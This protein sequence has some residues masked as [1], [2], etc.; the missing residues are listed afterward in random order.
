MLLL[1]LLALTAVFIPAA[2]AQPPDPDPGPARPRMLRS[3]DKGLV[4]ELD[5][6][7]ARV[8]PAGLVTIPGL[9][10]RL[11]APGAP[12]LPVYRTFIALPP[13]ATAVIDVTALAATSRAVPA[14]PPAPARSLRSAL[15]P[16]L[17]QPTADASGGLP[18]DLDLTSLREEEATAPDPALY[19]ADAA[20]PPALYTLSAP[21][22]AGD[23]RLVQLDLTPAQF[24]PA[25]GTLTQ[26][27]RLRVSLRFEGGAP[28]ETAVSP[29]LP[30]PWD[31]LLLNPPPPSWRARPALAAETAAAVTLPQGVPAFKIEVN[32]DGIYEISGADLAAAG[33]T[34]TG[35]NPSTL[36]MMHRGQPVAYQFVNT[37]SA[38]VLDPA[39]KIRFYGWAFDGSRYEDMFVD[40]NYY[41]LW[42]GGTALALGSVANEALNGH[43]TQTSF[44]ASITTWPK[45]AYF[46]GWG[47]PW[48]NNEATAWHWQYMGGIN[49]DAASPKLFHFTVELP[50][51]DPAG[52]API[53]TSEITTRK[54]TTA[55][56]PTY[57]MGAT[58]LLND[59]PASGSISWTNWAN[60][61]LV[62]TAAAVDL[63]QPGAAGYPGNKVTLAMTGSVA[64]RPDLATEAFLTRITVEYQRRL[65]ALNDELQFGP[66]AAGKHAFPISGFSQGSAAAALVWDITDR[67]QPKAITLATADFSSSSGVYT[68]Q[69]RRTLPANGRLF[70][71]TTANLRRPLAITRVVPA[72][73]AP[74][75]G[76]Q[77]LAIT[78]DSLRPAADALAAHRAATSGLSPFVVDVQQV[79][80]QVGF[81]Y[82]LPTAIQ[83]YL[84][85][86]YAT[87]ATP[88]RYVVLFGDATVNPTHRVCLPPTCGPSFLPDKPSLLA[89]DLLFIDRF[90]G[91]IPVDHTY[92]TLAGD[93]L[94]PDV[95]LSRVPA[96]N[97]AQANAGVEKIIRYETNL[98]AAGGPIFF[99]ADNADGGG[100]F[101]AE[102]ADVAAGLPAR[103][104]TAA[105]CL[106]DSSAA[107]TAVL[108]AALFDKIENGS[109]QIM[110][111]R[112]HG[113]TDSWASPAI[114]SIHD[115]AAWKNPEPLIHIS[116]DCL[117]GNFAGPAANGLGETFFRLPRAGTAAHWSSTGLGFSFEH[118]VLHNAYYKALFQEHLRRTG[119]AAL[120]AKLVYL[121]GSYH[122]VEALSFTLLGDAA[123]SAVP[124]DE[125]TLNLRAGWNMVSSPV[126]PDNAAMPALFA[127]IL[128]DLL[129]VKDGDGRVF[130]PA[131]GADTIGS[132]D[133]LRG[134]QI[135][136]NRAAALTF[137][138][139]LTDPRHTPIPLRAGW[140]LVAYPPTAPQAPAAALA[141]IGADLYL[142]KNGDGQVYWPE[143]PLDQI[144]T[145]RPGQGYQ[146]YMNA[147]GT[148]TYPD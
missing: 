55:G 33:L 3:D 121:S 105:L 51:P 100:N 35:V 5:L 41:W 81:G 34:L 64:G 129:L 128:S 118:S 148:L 103:L 32:Q 92:S 27:T 114:M 106:P 42:P 133:A 45:T 68:W 11:T 52:T 73:L 86:A 130:W 108:R 18:L 75:G 76:A 30:G 140:N 58:A 6:P 48:V 147:P 49:H 90:Q 62:S 119:D 116:A 110:N 50:D 22:Q 4:F 9:D 91:L 2:R 1:L 40:R 122:P 39:D 79:I 78:H 96:E 107:S 85:T 26:A 7:P 101:C 125:F 10:L 65:L 109:I 89:T 25:R 134:Y 127:P 87:W 124:T 77:W 141:T 104:A 115:T 139:Q 17:Q 99:V 44:P 74:P 145:M 131:I 60:L 102:S 59:Q 46:P 31:G 117:D 80:D 29:A 20:Y 53:L 142:A 94:L 28:R 38:A 15:P 71:T 113:S 132:W 24:N 84:K 16:D 143:L 126:A 138:G 56:R 12:A 112:G 120:F 67:L 43:Q 83:S 8:S 72:A 37:G 123:M 97:L 63:R 93:D 21:Q 137:R 57:T 14:I 36:Q 66:P 135:Y 47:I 82:H 23:L 69:V 144:Q 98:P 95:A 146:V 136:M 111:Y 88:P 13:A 61:N 54:S 19:S 70:A